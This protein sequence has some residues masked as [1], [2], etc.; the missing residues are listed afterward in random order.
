LA[1]GIAEAA[2]S[3]AGRHARLPHQLTAR[4]D[5]GLVTANLQRNPFEGGHVGSLLR[6]NPIG[7]ILLECDKGLARG[8]Y[9]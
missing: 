5:N 8:T 3:I 2:I 9:L 1:S 4:P 7:Q 6:A